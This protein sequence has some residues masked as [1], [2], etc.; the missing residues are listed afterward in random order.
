VTYFLLKPIDSS[1]K[2][3]TLLAWA[4]LY[5]LASGEFTIDD[6]EIDEEIVL[7]NLEDFLL[8]DDAAAY[9]AEPEA[10][11]TLVR[12]ALAAQIYDA[13][14][15]LSEAVPFQY[16]FEIAPEAGILLRL[17]GD[18]RAGFAGATYVAMQVE[19]L[20]RDD[21]LEVWNA[22]AGVTEEATDDF[23]APF[24]RLLEI[25]SAISV[26]RY[27]SGIPVVLGASRSVREA[28]IPALDEICK[29]IG[30]GQ[31]KKYDMLNPTQKAANDGGADAL[32]V[33]RD[34]D[35][36][37]ETA[38]VG[39]T[40]QQSDLRRKLVTDREIDRIRGYL[41]DPTILG[42][43]SGFLVHSDPFN[44]RTN[45]LCNEAKCIYFHRDKILE[46]LTVGDFAGRLQ[47]RGVLRSMKA[48]RDALD[49][50]SKI[51]VRVEF[52]YINLPC[53]PTI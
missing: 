24:R 16:P 28:L 7:E 4:E 23:L 25:V 43:T 52:Q 27:R 19:Q 46:H 6:L 5:C 31:P 45:G 34:K 18:F 3:G 1:P 20:Y 26:A 48:A 22:R 47:K 44:E 2:A 32:V 42:A 40:N 38:L 8:V 41:L 33:C 14:H 53:A 17:T 11:M 29:I 12:E 10:A 49:R 30:T 15:E 51:Q 9:R 37:V 35:R 36:A 50:L 13:A 39:A 21:L